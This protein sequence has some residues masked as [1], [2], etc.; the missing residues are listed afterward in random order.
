MTIS[1]RKFE[2]LETQKKALEAE[3]PEQKVFIDVHAEKLYIIN[4]DVFKQYIF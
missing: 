3:F 2:V 1:T 4:D